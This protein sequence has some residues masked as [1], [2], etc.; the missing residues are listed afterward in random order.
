MMSL[1][2]AVPEGIRE[3]ECKRF[4]L[5]EGPPAPYVPKKDPVQEMDS[6]LKSYRSLK[7]TIRED[8]ELALPIWHCGTCKAFLMHVCT[9]INRIK[10]QST[11]KAHAEAH[12]LY[13]EHCEV[14]KQV[15]ATL[16]VLNAATSKGEKTSKKASQKTKEGVALADTP[17]PELRAGYQTEFQKS[18]F[19][20]ET[21][22]N[23][24][25]ST[26]KEMFQFYANLLSADT[27]YAWKKIVKEQTETDP[28]KDLQGM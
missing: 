10:K 1:V 13:L 9:A 14:A 19:V 16:A 3:K 15:K 7:T 20:T 5:Q 27:K 22:K 26:A 17:D 11:F 28:F 24:Q 8:A 21:T 12:E 4:A 2:L 18:K 25:D 6:L 23:K